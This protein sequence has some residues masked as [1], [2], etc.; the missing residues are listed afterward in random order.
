MGSKARD[1]RDPLPAAP[2]TPGTPGDLDSALAR[3]DAL[4]N[5]EARPRR[6]GGF[7]LAPILDL[8]GR[9]GDPHRDLRV[10]HIAGTKGKGSVASLVAR[11]L[12][13][14]GL[15]VG[16]YGSP[17]VERVHERIELGDRS[18]SDSELIEGLE[19]VLAAVE[20]ARS[21]PGEPPASQA[22]WFDVLTATALVLF[23]RARLDWAVVECGLGGRLD[24]TNVLDG[25]V[26]V[27]TN[28]GLEHT[29]VLGSTHAEIAAEKAAIVGPGCVCVTGLPGRTSPGDPGSDGGILAAVEV[30]E[31]RVRDLGVPLRRPPRIAAGGDPRGV[32]FDARNLELAGEVLAA[33]GE[34]GVL[35]ADG[36]P[37]GPVLLDPGVRRAAR[38]PGRLERLWGE[39]PGGEAVPVVLDGAHVPESVVDLLDQL[40]LGV[41]P[42]FPG[43][44]VV[45]LGLGADKDLGGVLK[46]LVGRVD[47]VVCT[48]L[49]N[50]R[51]APPGEIRDQ[52]RAMGLEA[53]TVAKPGGA[54]L[55]ALAVA[56][57]GQGVLV[58]G[59][60]ILVGA[61]RAQLR[62]PDEAP[63][64]DDRL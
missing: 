50:P 28:V 61:V 47:R 45:V 55:R 19:K 9:L 29:E 21:E 20:D 59:S 57:P 10:V 13:A 37:I 14:A 27:L 52:A 41:I 31:K 15:A 34:R 60:L 44:P 25:E 18:V 11:A 56:S 48:S 22:T 32:G 42:D 36:E 33:L 16:R 3:L 1:P 6:R 7:T 30:L 53:E 35:G 5:W 24:S 38:L 23:R 17:H 26:C 62:L 63:D 58:T 54:L 49:G 4:T 8:L 64:A 51:S 43:A 2:G 46:A 39:G 40:A 12:S